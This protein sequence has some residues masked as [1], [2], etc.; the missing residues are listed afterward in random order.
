MKRS[1][2]GNLYKQV[3]LLKI[4]IFSNERARNFD[5]SIPHSNYLF[6]LVHCYCETINFVAYKKGLK[7]SE[8]RYSQLN[9]LGKTALA[10]DHSAV[11]LKNN[12][13]KDEEQKPI[14]LSQVNEDNPIDLHVLRN[15][16]KSINS[17]NPQVA[18]SKMTLQQLRKE[19][20]KMGIRWRDAVTDIK[21]G[22]KR[23]LRKAEIVAALEQKLSA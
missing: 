11:S 13:Y 6:H 21:T 1:E 20:S 22:K 2:A 23:D 17:A 12:T 8:V 5:G 7:V 16:S 4:R 19:C 9:L 18:L 15:F 3:Q 10:D 14:L